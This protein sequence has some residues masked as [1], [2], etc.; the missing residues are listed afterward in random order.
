MRFETITDL[1]S[2]P[3]YREFDRLMGEG[4]IH[5]HEHE[6]DQICINTVPGREDDLFYGRGSLQYDWDNA[7]TDE[8]G[9][10]HVPERAVP[11]REQ[12]FTVLCT[13]YRGTA[14]EQMY[15]SLTAR[16][17]VGRVRIM[18]MKSKKCLTWHTDTS[19]RI[20]Y[21]IKTQDGC[22]MVIEDEVKHLP[23]YTWTK[24]DTTLPHTAF[25]GSKDSR[26]HIVATII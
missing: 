9:R 6:R 22:F 4:V 15:E 13:Q 2:L 24:T 3:L 5:W 16:Y 18:N 19:P 23:L 20:H 14:F 25:N 26:Y 7:T 10:T 21:P 12:D 1:P 11:L 17:N 8:N